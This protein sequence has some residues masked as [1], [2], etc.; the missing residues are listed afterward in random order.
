MAVQIFLATVV[1]G[2]G[3]TVAQGVSDTLALGGLRIGLEPLHRQ[4]ILVKFRARGKCGHDETTQV[5]VF[6]NSVEGVL[7]RPLVQ[8]LQPSPV[9]V[10]L[11]ASCMLNG[12]AQGILKGAFVAVAQGSRRAVAQTG[13]G[14]LLKP[15]RAQGLSRNAG[16]NDRL[17]H[18]EVIIQSPWSIGTWRLTITSRIRRRVLEVESEREKIEDDQQ[19]IGTGEGFLLRVTTTALIS[20]CRR[21][22]TG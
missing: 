10:L 21:F 14:V 11:C 8:I 17:A 19:D 22:T 18:F 1:H 13:N 20:V 6:L 16:I 12:T 2:H 7:L 5:D 9:H 15:N 4:D 3:I